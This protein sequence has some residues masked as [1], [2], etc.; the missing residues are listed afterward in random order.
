LAG[1]PFFALGMGEDMRSLKTAV[2]VLAL[3]TAWSA[4]AQTQQA[5]EDDLTLPKFLT[6]ATCAVIGGAIFYLVADAL[7]TEPVVV[8]TTVGPTP[9]LVAGDM[10]E[11]SGIITASTIFGGTISAILG[12]LGYD[13]S[14]EDVARAW[15]EAVEWVQSLIQD[16]SALLDRAGRDVLP[17]PQHP[18]PPP[19]PDVS[20]IP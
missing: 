7:F 5:A 18:P 10:A 13:R 20:R 11:H 8:G 4:Q 2:V 12:G 15:S 14:H 17:A 16:G 19:T 3:L 9:T 6:I 1:K